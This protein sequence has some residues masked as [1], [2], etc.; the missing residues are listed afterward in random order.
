MNSNKE[1][2]IVTQ[3]ETGHLSPLAKAVIHHRLGLANTLVPM[4][5]MGSALPA[6]A[7][8]EGGTIVA[9]AGEISVSD[10]TTTID[11]DSSKLA[12]DWSSFN[13]AEDER[14][15]FLQ[16]SASALVLNR[17]LDEN[18]SLIH[19]QIDANGHVLL[20]NPRGLLFS[21]TSSVNVNSITASGLDIDPDDFMNGNLAFKAN[22]GDAGFVI[23]RGVI[24][25]ASGAVLQGN[26][27]ENAAGGLIA[28]DMVS[29]AAGSETVLTFDADKLIGI[30]V[31]KEV[32]ENQLG[33]DSALLNEGTIEAGEVLLTAKVAKGL[34]DNAVNNTGVVEAKGIDTSGGTI[35]LGGSGGDI[36]DVVNTGTVDASATGNG[37]QGGKVQI[38]G[39]T[40]ALKG[41][42]RII[43]SGENGGGIVLIGG[44]YQGK[45]PAIQNA[46]DVVVEAD[47]KIDASATD[48]GDGGKVIVW[49][50]ETAT[51]AGEITA[52]GGENGGNGGF[53]ETSGKQ[54]LKAN[55]K[56]DVG[57]N[58][59][60]NGEWL[61][62]P[63]NITITD[64]GGDYDADPVESTISAS[65]LQDALFNGGDVT[66]RTSADPSDGRT[67]P[68]P[69]EAGNITIDAALNPSIIAFQTSTLTL[70]ADNNIYVNN[71]LTSRD[72]GDF[73][74]N[75]TATNN[76]YIKEDVTIDT[77][78]GSFTSLSKGFYNLGSIDLKGLEL[79][80]GSYNVTI[81]YGDT[82]GSGYIGSYTN[83][84]STSFNGS[85]AGQQ[86]FIY[87]ADA[88]IDLSS[89]LSVNGTVLEDAEGVI[90]GN[91]TFNDV[92]KLH[93]L[94]ISQVGTLTG[95]DA[96]GEYALGLRDV[97]GGDRSYVGY[98]GYEF[99][100]LSTVTAGVDPTNTLTGTNNNNS[101]GLNGNSREFVAQGTVFKN[102][103]SVDA[104]GGDN[105][106][107]G[108][109]NQD[110]FVLNGSSDSITAN[111][112]LFTSVN[113]TI[114]TNGGNDAL[115]GTSADE[116]FNIQSGNKVITGDWTF[117]QIGSIDGGEGPGDF[118]NG[119]DRI[120]DST[121]SD[122]STADTAKQATSANGITVSNI[123]Y[124]AA[125]SRL[126][127]TS[128]LDQ[129]IT[130][131]GSRDMELMG[132]R[133]SGPDR[134]L[135]ATN[136]RT[137]TV[138]DLTTDS[139]WGFSDDGFLRK[140]GN[141]L[142]GIDVL[143][144]SQ[145][146]TNTGTERDVT[147]N[148]DSLTIGDLEV[149]GDGAYY[150]S[151]D[152]NVTDSLNN[153]WTITGLN[154]ASSGPSDDVR[155]FNGID[156]VL[157]T[158]TVTGLD[159]AVWGLGS[160]TDA[161][162]NITYN[163]SSSGIT[164]SGITQVLDT[165][166][167]ASTITL[168]N[169]TEAE[170]TVDVQSA[171]FTIQGIFFEGVSQY[172]GFGP[173]IIDD[174]VGGTYNVLDTN[175]ARNNSRGIGYTGISQ[176]NTSG[177]WIVNASGKD[178]DVT[179]G[180]QQNGADTLN[181]LSIENITF[182]GNGR[183]QGSADHNDNIID[184]TGRDWSIDGTANKALHDFGD[185][186]GSSTTTTRQFTEIDSVA[187]NGE[188]NEASTTNWISDS[189]NSAQADG[190]SF[191]SRA[192]D[193][194]L[195]VNTTG[196]ISSSL[197]SN[198][199]VKAKQNSLEINKVDFVGATHF[200]GDSTRNDAVVDEAGSDWTTN[201]TSKETSNDYHG[202]TGISRVLTNNRVSSLSSN[203]QSISVDADSLTIKDVQFVGAN[204]FDGSDS[205]TDAIAGDGTV[206][207]I[208]GDT[209]NSVTTGEADNA[210][211][212]S[213]TNI[214]SV[215][216]A[217]RISSSTNNSLSIT[218]TGN[219]LRLA[220]IDFINA[221]GFD[222][223]AARNETVID[224]DGNAWQ[225]SVD[226]LV[227]AL[228][229]NAP[230]TFTNINNVQGA[231]SVENASDAGATVILNDNGITAAGI[232]FLNSFV[233]KGSATQAD[234]V[235]ETASGQDGRTWSVDGTQSLSNGQHTLTLVDLL[236]TT[237][238][239]EEIN[240]FADNWRTS[241]DNTVIGAGMTFVDIDQVTL[242]SN[243]TA[244][245]IS[246]SSTTAAQDIEVKANALKLAAIDFIN[247]TGYTGNASR[248]DTVTDT[249]NSDWSTTGTANQ[250]NSSGRLFTG[251]TEVETSGRI[252]S[253]A[254]N[255]QSQQVIAD[256]DS[257]ET[258]GIDFVGADGFDG[259]VTRGDTIVDSSNRDWAVTANN[260][261][262]RDPDN[263]AQTFTGISG[264]TTTGDTRN[265][266]DADQDVV[267]GA[268]SVAFAG[269]TFE[270]SG[271]YIGS[272]SHEDNIDDQSNRA[273]GILGEKAAAQNP[274]LSER[275]FTHVDSV[276][277]NGLISN[278]TGSDLTV[279]I[280]RGVS[281][282]LSAEQ[283]LFSDISGYV[284]DINH[285]DTVNGSLGSN[286]YLTGLNSLNDR[287][288]GNGFSL[289][290]VDIV[291][292]GVT[293]IQNSGAGNNV[294]ATLRADN[295]LDVGGILFSEATSYTGNNTDNVFDNRNVDWKITGQ[296]G[297]KTGEGSGS[298]VFTFADIDSVTTAANVSGRAENSA[299]SVTDNLSAA[300]DG[301]VF[302]FTHPL[303]IKPQISNVGVISNGFS[304]GLDVT[305]NDD[306]NNSVS[307][308]SM[309]FNGA[310]GY[311]GHS[312]RTDSVTDARARNW[313]LTDYDSVT[314]DSELTLD[315][316]EA[317]A[318]FVISNIGEFTGLDTITNTDVE[319]ML[320][321][322]SSTGT[323][324]AAGILFN[325]AATYSGSGTDNVVDGYNQNWSV[326][327]EKSAT[328]GSL[329]FSGIDSVSTGNN[330]AGL[331]NDSTWSITGTRTA[332]SN[333]IAFS[334][335]D[336]DSTIS[337]V[338]SITNDSGDG[339]DIT[340]NNDNSLTITD[341]NFI[342]ATSY[343]GHDKTA[344]NERD[345]KITDRHNEA[346]TIEGNGE[347]ASAGV[348]FEKIDA[349]QTSS[350]IN[351][352]VGAGW[353]VT[354]DN[355]TPIATSSE[356]AFTG[357]SQVNNVGRLTNSTGSSQTVT[358]TGNNDLSLLDITFGRANAYT[359]HQTATGGDT[360][361]DE[362]N[363]GWLVENDRIATQQG[364]NR[365]FTNIAE[366]D[367]TG[368]VIN[369]T[370]TGQTVTLEDTQ[371]SVSNITFDGSK[372]YT[373]K[374]GAVEHVIDQTTTSGLW[375]AQGSS[376][377]RTN[378]HQLRDVDSI[379]TTRGV[380][381]AQVT[382]DAETVTLDDDSLTVAGIDYQGSTS[383]IG[384]GDHVVDQTT[385]STAWE[386]SNTQA[387]SKARD[388]QT[389]YTLTGITSVETDK[390]IINATIGSQD[391][392]LDDDSLEIAGIDFQ[393]A[394]TRYTGSNDGDNLTDST[395]GT[396][397]WSIDGERTVSKAGQ[398]LSG[399]KQLDTAK[400]INDSGNSDWTITGTK[401]A[402]SA[403]HG[404]AVD[405]T[406]QITTSGL[407]TNGSNSGQNVLL[408]DDQLT[409][410][411]ILFD[412]STDYTGRVGDGDVVNDQ[413]SGTGNWLVQGSGAATKD[414]HNLRNV[415]TVQTDNAVTNASGN[416]AIVGLEADGL[417][418]ADMVFTGASGYVGD[419]NASDSVTDALGRNWYLLGNNRLN[420]ESDGSGFDLSNIDAFT[421]LDSIQN[422]TA[423][424][425]V[426]VGTADNATT[427]TASNILF[428]GASSYSGSGSDNI[429]DNRT[430]LQNWQITDAN[431]L[432]TDAITFMGIDSVATPAD[433]VSN[434]ANNNWSVTGNRAAS[435]NGIA[436]S[437]ADADTTISQTG[438]VANSTGN[439]QDLTIKT[440]GSLQFADISFSGASGYQG[441][442]DASQGEDTVT[443][444][445]NSVWTVTGTKALT[446]GGQSFTN[447][448]AV[449]T[450]AAITSTGSADWTVSVEGTDTVATSNQIAFS[451]ISTVSNVG[452]L[453]NSTGVAQ[454][455][456]IKQ[457][458]KALELMGITFGD[459]TSYTGLGDQ[460][461]DENNSNWQ[462]DSDRQATELGEDRQ[463]TNI[464]RVA[465]TGSVTNATG[466]GKDVTLQ[467]NALSTSEI[468]F[469][470][471][472]DYIGDAGAGDHVIDQTTGTGNWQAKGTGKAEYSSHQLSNVES[473]ATDR[474][475]TNATN[476]EA[477]ETVIL[478][479]DSLT[480]AGIDF[481]GSTSYTGDG[482]IVDDQTTE[483]SPWRVTDSNAVSKARAAL[484]EYLL[485]NI[486]AVQTD[487]AI[488]NQTGNSQ[489]VTLDDDS[490]MLAG[491]DFQG[492]NASYTG[493]ASGDTLVDNTTGTEVWS[494]DSAQ[495][496]SR[497]SQSLTG[498]SR[499]ETGKA[500][501]EAST[502][503]WSVLDNGVA[504]G[505]AHQLTVD[506][507]NTINTT[508]AVT[509]ATATGQN[510]TL[511]DDQLTVA[512]I[513]FDGST[514]YTGRAGDG[515]VVNDQTT[516]SGNW[517][518]KGDG[519]AHKGTHEL[520][521]IETL[522]TS[523]G[524]TNDTG[525]AQAVTLSDSGLNLAG[526]DYQGSQSFTG[527]GD[528]VTDNTS[529]DLSWQ[530][531]ADSSGIKTVKGD[532]EMTN[533]AKVITDNALE[534]ATDASQSV[535]L[536]D[537]S[538][539]VAGIDFEGSRSYTG[540]QD[541]VV[542]GTS[543]NDSWL[544]RGAGATDKG[545]YA[546]SG[547]A[548]MATSKGV[549]NST[550]TRQT[551]TQSGDSLTV[552]DIEYQ[553]TTVYTGDSALQ[554]SVNSDK[555]AWQLYAENNT[556]SSTN[557]QS[558]TV[559]FNNVGTVNTAGNGALQ[560]TDANETF[561]ISADNTVATKGMTF[562]GIT[563]LD[564]GENTAGNDQ[565]TVEG[566]GQTWTLTGQENEVS[567]AGIVT[568][569]IE[570][571]SDTGTG[572]QQGRVVGTSGDDEFD[573]NANESPN[574]LIA[575]GI[576]FSGI[577][578]LNGNG[579]LGKD[580][581]SNE[582]AIW[583]LL[584]DSKAILTNGITI[585]NINSIQDGGE[586]TVEGTDAPDTFTLTGSDSFI[587]KEI[588]FSGINTITGQGDDIA[589]AG[590]N[591]AI[592]WQLTGNNAF[593]VGAMGFNGFS[594]INDNG[595][596]QLVGSAGA[597]SFN[598]AD[599][600]AL[601]TLGMNVTGIRMILAG[602]GADQVLGNNQAWAL[603][604][605][606]DN[607]VEVAGMT[608]MNLEA[609]SDT[610]G[611]GS[612]IGSNRADTITW[613][614]AGNLNSRGVNFTGVTSLDGGDGNDTVYID[615]E[616]NSLVTLT[617][618]NGD[619]DLLVNR[620]P[621]DGDVLGWNLQ[622]TTSTLGGQGFTSFERLSHELDTISLIT[623][624]NITLSANLIE[625]PD[626]LNTSI[627]T[628]AVPQ[629]ANMD[630]STEG[631]IN[632]FVKSDKVNF[633]AA[634]PV[635]IT[636]NNT[637][638]VDDIISGGGVTVDV[639]GGD[640]VI[641]GIV[642][643][644][645]SGEVIL[646]ASDNLLADGDG[647]HIKARD[648][649]LTAGQTVGSQE[650]QFLIDSEAGGT[651]D[652]VAN[653]YV[654][655]LFTDAEA[656]VS[657][658]GERLLSVSEAVALSGFRSSS[659][660]L[661][662][663]LGN[664][665]P[666]IFT[667]ISSFSVAENSAGEPQ[668][669]DFMLVENGNTTIEGLPVEAT[670]GGEGFDD[671]IS[672]TSADIENGA[673]CSTSGQ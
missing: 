418:I 369:N 42:A 308:A 259:E 566:L 513:R 613:Q 303:G 171:G 482:D 359:G 575:N 83:A 148:G 375:E 434:T 250:A 354:R 46:R 420:A 257:L 662:N 637:L 300:S 240:A 146:V 34:F 668:V 525:S 157:T 485:T 411:G 61:L 495:A 656:E 13:V 163:A 414:D 248:G 260:N 213:F 67:F 645:G 666:A 464:T 325:N 128:A 368:R 82:D 421:G 75:F 470:G 111:D 64:T 556:A 329:S 544:V 643:A 204:G 139:S 306:A 54:T 165:A 124:I 536:D 296:Y 25:A 510:V 529:D 467:D 76:V 15:Q 425:N 537:D 81:G 24:N 149:I 357:I 546:L 281:N 382:P 352:I 440:D 647:V 461:T 309:Q 196:R 549:Q 342:G 391:V 569:N 62:D 216:G 539:A 393:G 552:A 2:S 310:T 660:Q 175:A 372:S 153:D 297:A 397:S 422:Q 614:G 492:A 403:T 275:R 351:S 611:N 543:G 246:S 670:A 447:I 489:R 265:T 121:D 657:T 472:T 18:P 346:W 178:Q 17:I 589:E 582:N 12:I 401:A 28:A 221:S 56:V 160:V 384:D 180:T 193:N 302:N 563:A 612:F 580:I 234:L 490:L 37:S 215:T 53:V 176:V 77:H 608:F 20:I 190:I 636:A 255:A 154:A 667:E 599:E 475:V 143:Q 654:S 623:N 578:D 436:F 80:T 252:S 474:G 43:A 135:A 168:R 312:T 460:I 607:E 343:Q 601:S 26:H 315:S 220:A 324:S 381:N 127:S 430:Q 126:S 344:P 600:N 649:S 63:I 551:V 278:Q 191:S 572:D 238:A 3:S 130:Y 94:A 395:T 491:V 642:S 423:N 321:E 92:T 631:G 55:G 496:I 400:N 258:N 30:K 229:G 222:G 291:S 219:T 652:I 5:L 367:T 431:D 558:Q 48:N 441:H 522:V 280:T 574:S 131:R 293:S 209:N 534:N 336:A 272:S 535:T 144:T 521:N 223:R 380:I 340:R 134:F 520:R 655:P 648:I 179:L 227:R 565:D 273:W 87:N 356:I 442:A 376:N 538:I 167:S 555:D 505:T 389:G 609:V 488:E 596:G 7:G 598:I 85:S 561:V 586:G 199:V 232:G 114:T 214:D 416:D 394:N 530:L 437:F 339:L 462:T 322:I 577:G 202:F 6:F 588:Q 428:N 58:N 292:G 550:G 362:T 116:T 119:Y 39:D 285:T 181:T 107:T 547:I 162:N 307:V 554:D 568:S 553:G 36:S 483:A 97:E 396:D 410:A 646:T 60:A 671:N 102:F 331:A 228:T 564:A 101:F 386:V 506:G 665:D 186:Q 433:V 634:G 439:G 19:G 66:L 205:R 22:E 452:S 541:S 263:T 644:G 528:T 350:E 673:D 282:T 267:L 398:T 477:A 132:I 9:G 71:N 314:G 44:D 412:G 628:G 11:Q 562:T 289:Q 595:L 407:V 27:V 454:D 305:L 93:S 90:F 57:A 399:I 409:A 641:N 169:L 115:T 192:P 392:T 466:A 481:Q 194:S 603:G 533:V 444:E 33:V 23:N 208:T 480:V 140:D 526:V 353:V 363:S 69:G 151:G 567:A 98:R 32:L 548:S 453:T 514:D 338:G 486:N 247:A 41:N 669:G 378:T 254:A 629:F 172:E 109:S 318:P 243:G 73:A 473:V 244:G 38:E 237:S 413:T 88:N 500:I 198:Q 581:V 619:G 231:G 145:S 264:V 136:D 158:G 224:S 251:I 99:Y 532:V 319:N 1:L 361:T 316:T 448:D 570:L 274:G 49:S 45:N 622:R 166:N 270:N 183:Y 573:L 640:L 379:Q 122:W 96:S 417:H 184:N 341:I 262:T 21:E 337:N 156:S 355:A 545:E 197:T 605:T 594:N 226:G 29:L 40:I 159:N 150:G 299:W 374:A 515:D 235:T 501:T 516:G 406:S 84:S 438:L 377:A 242:N 494:I 451:G 517:L 170:Q 478:D 479:D 625:T 89:G 347:L 78:G 332:V 426:V 615:G 457:T 200:D 217:G 106:I 120:T 51:F 585:T 152:D 597:D 239:V 233:Y 287:E 298:P 206:D 236:R 664:V 429:T 185:T 450:S 358:I 266:T 91:V 449:D 621:I 245:N 576:L 294:N 269:I 503:D 31:T 249:T 277:T 253:S 606:A 86:Y 661:V 560:G 498:I 402:S 507:S 371:L 633:G 103:D 334:L 583:K 626:S 432:Q 137:D 323:L 365:T 188:V 493:D 79:D 527:N 225:I 639:D 330:I 284:G 311:T 390:H 10:K 47:V 604:D 118:G 658:I 618:G 141:I 463:F 313:T 349:V 504:F 110:A 424:Q 177:G 104:S 427:I 268:N 592:N 523:Q 617:G 261:A 360:V 301:I 508:G 435:S 335:T 100:G 59:G 542:D 68:D 540:Q 74:F 445:R 638:T 138:V 133:F 113:N 108:S 469:A 559:T 241:D 484:T 630:L 653:Q 14:V 182:V 519:E 373:G 455:V 511:E 189:A 256:S 195:I 271:D 419:E 70:I 276:T 408:E 456:T 502:S 364:A 173:D 476:I 35:R 164:F 286:W 415:E 348:S 487:K 117:T 8:P 370:A 624:S 446:S 587:A 201:E 468:T 317:G 518:A 610:S 443:D 385:E 557:D 320:V 52:R 72:A 161:L 290:N 50:D 218:A 579:S 129:T 650:L 659:Q 366:V 203:N 499:L 147:I 326:T 383:Y 620:T 672:C 279:S 571:V 112:I 404:L 211:R 590:D 105:I 155:N 187:T 304:N 632:G 387:V 16:P 509:N 95:S 663:Q 471:S 230:Q 465:T 123:D 283:I 210:D 512:G 65:S 328:A 627:E 458:T 4:M 593:S 288:A 497:N 212:R 142:E 459:A 584:S 174:A 295:Q 327:G 207:W 531:Q 125:V 405:G 602:D 651:V 616:V 524:V 388:S 635:G 591:A 333:A 345:D